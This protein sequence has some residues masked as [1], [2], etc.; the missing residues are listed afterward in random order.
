MRF[1]WKEIGIWSIKMYDDKNIPNDG[2]KGYCR[3][4]LYV[5]VSFF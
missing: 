4:L 2:A 1:I 5:K 3:I